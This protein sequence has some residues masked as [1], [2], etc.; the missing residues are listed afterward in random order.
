MKVENKQQFPA[1]RKPSKKLRARAA[2]VA[3]KR[4]KSSIQ[5]VIRI[6]CYTAVLCVVTQHSSPHK[7]RLCSRMP[8]R[9][10]PFKCNR[11]LFQNEGRCSAF[12][13]EII[14]HSHANKTHYFGGAR[15]KGFATLRNVSKLQ[16]FA[17]IGHAKSVGFRIYSAI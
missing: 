8:F 15:S 13:I 3:S 6:V 12:D 4:G 14:F 16:F 10:T 17:K 9:T 11:P 2:K 7:E 1:K 5:D